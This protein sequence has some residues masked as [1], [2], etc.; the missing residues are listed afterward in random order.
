M[1]AY[2]ASQTDLESAKQTRLY[3][4]EDASRLLRKSNLPQPRR[5]GFTSQ[6]SGPPIQ[7]REDVVCRD[8]PSTR[9]NSYIPDSLGFIT[10]GSESESEKFLIPSMRLDYQWSGTWWFTKYSHRRYRCECLPSRDS[11]YFSTYYMLLTFHSGLRDEDVEQVIQNV[12][13]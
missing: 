8:S 4:V 12:C 10:G 2:Q 1:I 9:T 5:D 11:Q 6:W 7:N 13:T 3:A